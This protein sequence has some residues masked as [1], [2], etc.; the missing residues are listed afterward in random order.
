MSAQERLN[1]AID[2]MVARLAAR[3]SNGWRPDPEVEYPADVCEWCGGP[4]GPRCAECTA[5][6]VK[7]VLEPER[8]RHELLPDECSLCKAPVPRRVPTFERRNDNA[9]VMRSRFATSRCPACG[10]RI[11]E[12]EWIG[13]DDF[14]RWVHSECVE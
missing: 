7:A 14:G 9:Y 3:V 5:M 12:G 8:C 11:D 1:T 13:K 6:F 2:G 10:D 4:D